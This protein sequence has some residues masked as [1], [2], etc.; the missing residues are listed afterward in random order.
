MA[1]P[2]MASLFS[3]VRKY[4]LG[5]T[6]AAR[7][8]AAAVFGAM[9]LWMQREE[10]PLPELATLCHQALACLEEGMFRHY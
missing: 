1:T 7:C 9:E 6:V 2:S 3:G 8:I 4:R 10:R 5:V